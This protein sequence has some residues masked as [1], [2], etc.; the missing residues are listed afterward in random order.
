MRTDDMLQAIYD[1]IQHQ[2]K[3]PY[4][5]AG[6]LNGAL[7]A[8]PTIHSRIAEGSLVDIGEHASMFGKMDAAPTC[9]PHNSS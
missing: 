6:D 5:I 1:E 8:F 9:F 4:I 3:M 7:Q 2:P